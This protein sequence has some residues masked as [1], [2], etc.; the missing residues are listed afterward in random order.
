SNDGSDLNNK[1]IVNRLV[2][3]NT[4]FLF[5]GDAELSTENKILQRGYNIKSD[6][7]KVGHHGSDTSTSE[8]FLE[9]I[10]PKHAIISVGENSYGHPTSAVLNRLNDHNVNVYR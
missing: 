6:V 10:S 9:T 1:S 8:K 4:S 2:F 7:L 5:T 3:G